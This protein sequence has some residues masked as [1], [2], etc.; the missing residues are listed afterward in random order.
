MSF[1]PERSSILDCGFGAKGS[2]SWSYMCYRRSS[3]RSKWPMRFTGPRQ[4]VLANDLNYHI[5]IISY[6][7]IY[8]SIYSP[9]FHRFW[10]YIKCFGLQNLNSFAL[11]F[12]FSHI[13]ETPSAQ[14]QT[15]NGYVN[16]KRDNL[17]RSNDE[18]CRA[19]FNASSKKKEKDYQHLPNKKKT[20][21]G[22]QQQKICGFW[23]LFA[24]SG[25]WLCW[26]SG[27]L[28]VSTGGFTE[29]AKLRS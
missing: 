8:I 13:L 14:V 26:V 16:G 7:N 19:Y 2:L 21:F 28:S 25:P 6:H 9:N 4:M 11:P 12:D 15:P 24:G 10:N 29:A 5:S 22:L 23:C 1:F 18:F 17:R 20:R 27:S 3:F